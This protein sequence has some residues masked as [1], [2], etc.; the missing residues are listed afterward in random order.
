[1][2]KTLTHSFTSKKGVSI[3]AGE[4]VEV[5]FNVKGK[6]TSDFLPNFVSLTTADNRR[7]ITGRLEQLGFEKPSLAKLEHYSCD[8]VAKSVFG[9]P[10]EPDGWSHDGSPSWLLALGLI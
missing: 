2:K 9:S 8:G 5:K 7:I 6:G 1:M 10:V 4:Q 3:N